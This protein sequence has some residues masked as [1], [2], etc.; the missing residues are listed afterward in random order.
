MNILEDF[1]HIKT[2]MFD[3]DGVMT[4]ASVLITE[5]GELLRTMNVRDGFAMKR[6]VDVGYQIF[7]ITGGRSVGVVDRLQGLGV[8][9]IVSGADDKLKFYEDYV[10]ENNLDENRILYMG[11]DVAD[12]DVM[13]RVGFPVCPQ[14]AVPEIIEICRYVSPFKGGHGAVRDVIEK[15]MK[16]RGKW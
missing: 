6:A 14:D 5:Q 15:T 3:V 12:F 16:L 13:R 10:A 11:D 1:R 9:N 8:T 7:I 4:D 2:F